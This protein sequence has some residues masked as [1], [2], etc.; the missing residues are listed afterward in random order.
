MLYEKMYG[1]APSEDPFLNSCNNRII[2]SAEVLKIIENERS[3]V[4]NGVKRKSEFQTNFEKRSTLI[5]QQ[6]KPLNHQS[7]PDSQLKKPKKPPLQ[8]HSDQGT[9][10]AAVNGFC[11]N[12]SNSNLSMAK[13]DL[14]NFK[15]KQV[16]VRLPNGKRRI[17]PL[18]LS[19]EHP[20][21]NEKFR[22]QSPVAQINSCVEVRNHQHPQTDSYQLNQNETKKVVL[23]ESPKTLQTVPK[24]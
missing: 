14:P 16:E 13:D 10:I 17:T 4:E 12:S 11:T 5:E 18:S 15:K 22:S 23:H 9:T 19:T 8:S 2:E 3:K 1:K 21:Y 20:E 6:S 7:E 24:K